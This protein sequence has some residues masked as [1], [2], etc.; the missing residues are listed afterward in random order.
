M[1]ASVQLRPDGRY[2]FVVENLTLAVIDQQTLDGLGN[3]KAQLLNGQANPDVF[4]ALSLTATMVGSQVEY[5]HGN[6]RRV[7]GE[8]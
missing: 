3:F 8:Q 4:G 7:F 1:L 2:N 5:I 6:I